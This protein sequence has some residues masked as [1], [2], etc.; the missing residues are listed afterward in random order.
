MGA[1]LRALRTPSRAMP[2]REQLLVGIN[3]RIEI[4]VH[5]CQ[6]GE[7]VQFILLGFCCL[8]NSVPVRVIL[9][10]RSVKLT[11]SLS[12]PPPTRHGNAILPA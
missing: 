9:E 5:W 8:C 2:Q 6:F 7:C 11:T 1:S 12:S 10:S 4:I 3:R